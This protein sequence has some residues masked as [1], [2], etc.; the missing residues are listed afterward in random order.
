MEHLEES[1]T[2]KLAVALALGVVVQTRERVVLQKFEE[3][4][5]LV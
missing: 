5:V 3:G 2:R 4:M 1:Y